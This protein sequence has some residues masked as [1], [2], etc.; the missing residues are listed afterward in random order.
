MQP[1][2]STDHVQLRSQP[3]LADDD[4]DRSDCVLPETFRR[5]VLFNVVQHVLCYVFLAE[6][7]PSSSVLCE[8][9]LNFGGVGTKSTG[10]AHP[11]L[12]E[13]I[14][15]LFDCHS[16][17]TVLNDCDADLNFIDW[18]GDHCREHVPTL[19]VCPRERDYDPK[20][21][22]VPTPFST[23][24]TAMPT[25]SPTPRDNGGASGSGFDGAEGA[26]LSSSSKST[27]VLRR[28]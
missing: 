19:D 8:G 17:A 6:I 25:V 10:Y 28:G 27:F 22:G 23:A 4:R 12:H 11:P 14:S 24:M 16:W 9:Q 20:I 5:K 1:I 13:L 3:R 15:L 2:N 18:F 21:T 26:N 7:T